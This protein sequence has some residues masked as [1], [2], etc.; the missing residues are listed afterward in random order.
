MPPSENV[1]LVNFL[2]DLLNNYL[3]PGRIEFLVALSSEPDTE[4]TNKWVEDYAKDLA[5][6]LI[7][8]KESTDAADNL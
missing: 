3:T 4:H 5:S 7:D 6:R 2:Y 1:K 8:D